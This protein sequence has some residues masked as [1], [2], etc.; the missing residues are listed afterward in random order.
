LRWISRRLTPRFTKIGLPWESKRIVNALLI[1]GR[2]G[3]GP[4]MGGGNDEEGEMGGGL[5]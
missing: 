4:Q 1:S 3:G 2:G 5:H